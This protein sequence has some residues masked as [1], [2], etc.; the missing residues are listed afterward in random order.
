MHILNSNSNP[1]HVSSSFPLK[2]EPNTEQP[3]R[4]LPFKKS[5]VNTDRKT[6]E[7]EQLNQVGLFLLLF[8]RMMDEF[9]SSL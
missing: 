9:L 5:L 3:W 8:S 1:N 7:L 2:K 4:Y 6:P